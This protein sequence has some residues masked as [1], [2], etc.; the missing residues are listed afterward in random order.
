MDAQAYRTLLSEHGLV[1]SMARRGNPYD[2]AMM[3][4]S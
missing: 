1:G 2:N 3:E 4:A